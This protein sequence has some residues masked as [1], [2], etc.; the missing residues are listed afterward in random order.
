M[1]FPAFYTVKEFVQ[2]T[3]NNPIDWWDINIEM[4]IASSQR[5]T[6][7]VN[8]NDKHTK[9]MMKTTKPRYAAQSLQYVNLNFTPDLITQGY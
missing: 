1:Y 9:W 4:A 2:G 8:D 5:E 7:I 3:S 6:G